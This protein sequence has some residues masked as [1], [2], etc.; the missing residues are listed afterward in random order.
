MHDGQ[1]G[2]CFVR[3][4]EHGEV[5]LNAW[6]RSSG[7][8]VDPVEKKPLNH[9]YP[10]SAV[11]S[12]G[13]AGCNL[14]CRFCQNWDISKSR[15]TDTLATAATPDDVAETALAHGC[16]AVALTYNDPVV[17]H[18]Y[19]RDIAAAAR[20][21][22]LG[23]IGVT[24]GYV[25]A[26]ARAAFF[27]SFDAVNVDLKAFTDG[28]YRRLAGGALAPVLASLEYLVRETDIWLELTCLLIPGQNDSDDEIRAL[29]AWVAAQLGPDVP[30][31]FSAF[32]PDW[33]MRDTP[34]TPPA[35]V[36]RARAMALAEG[37]H[38]VYTGNIV[39]AAGDCTRCQDCGET[40]I[41]RDWY[42]LRDYRLVDGGH[43]PACGA[44]LAGVFAARPASAWGRRRLR[45]AP[46]AAP[47]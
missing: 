31:H 41:R 18:E 28:F 44:P 42:E 4:A 26:H 16:S 35:T 14:A 11:L 30:L 15:E 13:T 5:V 20:A 40:L 7:L 39:D 32:H 47:D 23:V 46:V 33:K 10:G 17:F 24:A 45:V 29:S 2:A 19:A 27:A 43:C 6:G 25:S 12:L 1:Q 38:H 9:Y 36:R 3:G 21:N 22:G 34:R 37:L 8:C